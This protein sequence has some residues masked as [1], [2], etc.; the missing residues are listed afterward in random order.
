MTIIRGMPSG[1]SKAIITF[2]WAVEMRIPA[3]RFFRRKKTNL[4]PELLGEI[5]RDNQQYSWNIDSKLGTFTQ[6][7]R[8]P[9]RELKHK[10]PTQLFLLLPLFYKGK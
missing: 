6:Q 2:G 8:N 1:K 4:G 9:L 3:L 7:K 10:T 5:Q